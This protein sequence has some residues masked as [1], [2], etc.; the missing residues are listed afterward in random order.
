MALRRFAEDASVRDPED[1]GRTHAGLTLQGKRAAMGLRSGP[2]DRQAK[3]GSSIL[4]PLRAIHLPERL[5]NRA[6][7]LRRAADARVAHAHQQI[8][9]RHAVP[10][11]AQSPS[12]AA[13][14]PSQLSFAR[15]RLHLAAPERHTS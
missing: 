4:A 7:V 6:K 5:Q 10:A 9:V 13:R 3:P 2:A 8:D 15:G 11:R 1:R 14:T 12:G